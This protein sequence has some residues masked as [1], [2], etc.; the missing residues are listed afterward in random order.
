MN[1][2]ICCNLD[3]LMLTH[4]KVYFILCCDLPELSDI[5]SSPYLHT[6]LEAQYALSCGEQVAN[7]SKQLNYDA[8]HYTC[9]KHNFVNQ[10][11][12]VKEL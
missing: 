7:H 11:Q 2:G 6:K 12:F 8:T 9:T 3:T 4:N 1:M 5:Q 10:T